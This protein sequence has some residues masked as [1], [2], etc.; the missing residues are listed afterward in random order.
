MEKFF[1]IKCRYSGLIP[2]CVVMVATGMH[3][4][5]IVVIFGLFVSVTMMA[6]T[7][8]HRRNQRKEDSLHLI[9]MERPRIG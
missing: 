1:D 7:Q 3:V 8:F 6:V 4:N 9:G 5:A 2:N